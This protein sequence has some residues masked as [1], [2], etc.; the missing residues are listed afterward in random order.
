MAMA[1]CRVRTSAATNQHMLAYD[2]GPSVDISH[3]FLQDDVAYYTIALT[4]G[5]PGRADTLVS[6]SFLEMQQLHAKVCEY[7]SSRHRC[8]QT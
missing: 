6:R 8:V 3:C 1:L 2:C 7:S 4:A 5:N